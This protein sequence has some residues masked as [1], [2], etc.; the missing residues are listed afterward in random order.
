M[1]QQLVYLNGQ[2]MPMDQ[3]HISPMDRG[4]LFG[5]GVYEVIPVYQRKIF[6]WDAHLDR[7]KNSL[8]AVSIH[9]P[10]NDQAWLALMQQLIQHHPWDDQAIYLQVTRGVQIPRDHLPAANLTPTIYAYTS[11]LK[12]I[13]ETVLHQ[14]IKVIT[15]DDIRW[16]HC[17]IKAITL[18]P[19]VMSKL[20]AQAAG[21]DDAILI[22]PDGKVSEGTASNLFIIKN[23]QIITPPNSS[24]ILPGITKKVIEKL[25]Q[26]HYLPFIERE[27]FTDELDNADELWLSSSIKEVLPITQ[28]NAKPVAN[29]KPGLVWQTLHQYY[30]TYKTEFINAN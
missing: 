18:L 19:N 9:N 14:G 10:H 3:A 5:D 25:A 20:L 23:N 8:I 28:L 26:R 16:H 11:Q 21:V 22:R 24:T 1:S 13:N 2:F 29:G 4:F 12:P 7:L 30:Q 27:V 6:E 17:D 15:V